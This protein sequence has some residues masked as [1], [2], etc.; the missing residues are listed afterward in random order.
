[1]TCDRFRGRILSFDERAAEVYGDMAAQAERAGTRLNIADGQIAAIA[2]VHGMQ[3]ATRDIG[4]FEAS[5][6]EL[7]NP[8]N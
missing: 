1:M 3:I 4:G 8:W 2:L 6:A 7:I 5:G